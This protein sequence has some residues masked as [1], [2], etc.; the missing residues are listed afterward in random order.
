MHVVVIGSTGLVGSRLAARLRSDGHRVTGASRGATGE[1]HI[2][3]DLGAASAQDWAR[4]LKGVDAVVNCAG[5]LQDA[6]DQSLASVHAE[7]LRR[8]CEGMR[9]AGVSRLIHIS[10]VGASAQGPSAFSRSKASGEQIVSASH[11]DWVILRPAVIF[12]RAAYGGSALL[13]GAAALPV[14]PV[15]PDTGDLQIVALDDVIETI[16]RALKDRAINRVAIDLVGP[17]RLSFNATVARLRTWLGRE[18]APLWRVPAGLAQLGYWLGDMAGGLG[19][20]SPVRSNA[21]A[22]ILRGATGDPAAWSA[23]TGLKPR[24]LDRLLE[25]QPPSVQEQWFSNLYLLKPVMFVVFSLFWIGTGLIAL[26][27]GWEQGYGVVVAGG[28]P[29]AIAA[30]LVIGGAAC[31]MLIGLAILYRPT[32]R[33]GLYAGLAISLIYFVIGTIVAPQLWSDPLGPMLKIWPIMALNLAML[34]ILRDR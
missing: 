10:A 20:K 8:L 28:V 13:R 15:L 22:E 27:P 7:G 17:Q 34:A 33:Y 14:Q 11:L 23:A 30:V 18:P 4:W 31:D 21:K 26:G 9:G 12:D 24:A 3:A 6:P 16:V 19:W 29:P 25:E 2:K 32:S 1:S 5:A